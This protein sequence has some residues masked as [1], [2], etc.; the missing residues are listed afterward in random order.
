[1]RSPI[2]AKA[3]L[4]LPALAVLAAMSGPAAAADSLG[5]LLNQIAP[6]KIPQGSVDVLSWVEQGK[7]GSELVV[8]L[9][10]KGQVKLVADP[11]VTVTPVARNGVAWQDGAPV[12]KIEPDRDYFAEPPT[13]RVPFA[14]NDGKPVEAEVEYAYCLVDYQCLF[15]TTKVTAPTDVPRG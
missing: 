14:G 8:S 9:V 2:L 3:A 10:P 15:G 6:P 7:Q 13:V 5:S 11:G 1:M 12:S 4:S